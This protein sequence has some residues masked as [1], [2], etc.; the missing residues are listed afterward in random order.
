MNPHLNFGLDLTAGMP[1]C[2]GM[3]F[4]NRLTR[5]QILFVT[6]CILAVAAFRILSGTLL[7]GL[8]NF[9]PVMALAFC[10]GLFLPGIAAFLVPIAAVWI[11]DAG[12]ALAKGY[13]VF[14]S[15]QI[16]SLVCLVAAVAVGRWLGRRP[17]FGLLSFF[18]LLLASGL[19][20]YLITNA[21]TWF[22]S[23]EYAKNLSGFVQAQTTG[24]PGLPPAWTFLRNSLISD[25][26]FGGILLAVRGLARSDI[27][28]AQPLHVQV[29]D[30]THPSRS[31]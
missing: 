15:W 7:P 2:D 22:V 23:P 13:P 8:P 24:L 25:I 3:T 31:L 28:L 19:G 16:V 14:G 1:H 26:L 10:G 5:P 21:A 30:K 11:S 18:G 29:G 20:F 17:S 12:L 27:Q 4:S 9:S 6:G